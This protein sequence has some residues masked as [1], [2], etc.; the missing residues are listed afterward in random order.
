MEKNI[1][2][3]FFL[4][5]YLKKSSSDSNSNNNRINTSKSVI[6]SNLNYNLTTT[7]NGN[8]IN[9]DLSMNFQNIFNCYVLP[10]LNI[11]DVIN[12]KLTNKLL[13]FL[14]NEKGIK[15]T[16]LSN[17]IK[18]NFT[19]NQYYNIWSYYMNLE[20][21]KENILKNDKNEKINEIEYYNN[22]K[23]TVI[24]IKNSN[25]NDKKTHIGQLKE[26]FDT[27]S[28]DI[29]RTY[30]NDFFTK[31][32]GIEM[33][34]NNLECIN[35]APNSLGYIQGMNFISGGFIYILKDEI[36]SYYLF[37]CLLYTYDLKNLYSYNTPDYNIRVY[38]LNYYVKKY[39]PE[40]FYHFKKENLPF[41]LLYSNWIITIFSN[42]FDINNLYYPFTLFILNKWKGIIKLC[43]LLINDLKDKLIN[44][45]LEELSKLMQNI[46]ETKNIKL[47]HNLEKNFNLYF[48]FKVT[49]QELK[50][51]R[52]DYY[53]DLA[54]N[55]LENIKFESWEND[56][57]NALNEY[58]TDKK[59]LEINVKKDI[60]NY[61]KLNEEINLKY[62]IA[63][64][65]YNIQNKIIN[66]LKI[67]IDK[68]AN[69][70]YSYEELF[71]FY[72]INIKSIK[73]KI[74]IKNLKNDFKIKKKSHEEKNKI[75]ILTKEMNKII[76]KYTPILNDYLNKTE[77]L[78][79]KINNIDKYKF[80]L[81]NLEKKKLNRKIDMENYLI[82]YEKKN[83]EL[84]KELC[85]K[86]KL[87]ENFKKNNKF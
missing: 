49:N 11:K 15:Y 80:E 75:E 19:P 2:E 83:N 44:I 40:I 55:K 61:K 77:L 28:R 8:N 50:N 17:S 12:L 20:A 21:Y 65:N 86:L 22:L 70:K 72:K 78:Y 45:N 54:K 84:I 47:F 74:E 18:N 76:E 4:T 29:T 3:K 30:H 51:L 52:D 26:N 62:L 24:N 5:N 14:I 48:K 9:Y 32:N 81:E 34:K 10:Y 66:N 38:Q 64:K 87:S 7:S 68:I 69:E 1:F 23:Q 27:I 16:I 42:Y 53:I 67:N 6:S 79:N 46:H 63:L 59:K 60:E 13:N 36:K 39:F 35:A 73:N 33:L 41:D 82:M 71:N 31:E 25:E 57:K 58:L 85:E 37:S 56:Q 43:L